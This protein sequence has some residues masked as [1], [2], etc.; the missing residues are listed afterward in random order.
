MEGD[1]RLEDAETGTTCEIT[2]TA[3]LVEQYKARLTSYCEEL[4][5]TCV[6]LGIGTA[7]VPTDI[8]M[9]T[10]LVEYLRSRGLLR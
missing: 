3:P 4:R 8:D 5:E 2:V 9:E 1:V 7:R 6:R 10:L